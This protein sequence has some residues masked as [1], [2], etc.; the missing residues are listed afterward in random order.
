MDPLKYIIQVQKTL[1]TQNA[2]IFQ[3]PG[4]INIIGEHTDYNQG[5]CIPAAIDKSIYFGITPSHET[6][7]ISLD[8]NNNWFPKQD[9]RM[10]DWAIYFKGVMDLL[11]QKGYSW[12]YFKLVFGGDLPIGAGLSSSSAITCGFISILNEFAELN[13]S[14]E[15]LTS[16]A[17]QAEKASGL[18]GGMMDQICIMNGKKDHALMIDCSNWKYI[19]L[20]ISFP[21][22]SWLVVDTKVKHKLVD[23]E[24]NSRS[25]SCREIL[26]TAKQ[27]FHEMNSLS[28]LDENMI[29]K[30]KS[31]LS[32]GKSEMLQYIFD[33]NMRVI[34]MEDAINHSDFN[35]MG[36][37]LFEGH[38]GLRKQYQVSCEELDFLVDYAKH[39]GSAYGARMMGGGFGGSTLHLI[40][41]STKQNY[42][43][44]IANAYKNRFG[45]YPEVFEAVT[46]DG[47]HEERGKEQ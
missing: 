40:P 21:D 45:F 28:Q 10:P 11:K 39:N 18:D 9:K 16:L 8:Q 43:I 4:R 15:K 12:P 35:S 30:I 37:L 2:L 20:P 26:Q 23:T 24:Y 47:V 14:K 46:C 13:I 27:M 31:Q 41:Q 3:A 42:Q 5:L 44:G 38:D 7:I 34:R 29:S 1:A 19:Y 33:E 17:V 25:T 32:K 6:E 36:N 22:V